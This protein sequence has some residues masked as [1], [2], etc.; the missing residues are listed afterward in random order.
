MDVHCAAT[1]LKWK[2][3][4]N[5]GRPVASPWATVAALAAT[6]VFDQRMGWQWNR[7]KGT[8]FA[9]EQNARDLLSAGAGALGMPPAVSDFK[10]LGV[11]YSF[12][13][14]DPVRDGVHERIETRLRRIGVPNS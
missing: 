14:L 5:G 11:Q 3:S 8:L 2:P 12:G 9:S 1:K 6:K 13:G 10:N 4:K 7:D